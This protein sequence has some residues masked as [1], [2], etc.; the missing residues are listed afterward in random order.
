MIKLKRITCWPDRLRAYKVMLDGKEIGKIKNG[1]EREFDA[2][3]GRHRL[4]LKIDWC[5]S[6][7]VDFET[8]GNAVEFE[9]GSNL[10]EGKALLAILYITFLRDHYIWLK[11][12][13]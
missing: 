11:R 1:E 13:V 10:T 9:C 6:N 8:P 3:A 7:T 5:G 2:P 4:C 12:T